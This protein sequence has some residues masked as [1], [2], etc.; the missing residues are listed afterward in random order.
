M[1]PFR[2][3]LAAQADGWW[4][5]SVIPWYKPNPMP[6]SVRKRPTTGGHEYIL[7]LS[8]SG[9]A[10]YWTHERKRGSRTKPKADYVWKHK[11]MD[12]VVDYPPVSKR[13]LKKFWSRSN[14]WKG[15]DYFYDIDAVRKPQTD[16]FAK[17]PR[18]RP[19][20][21]YD[22]AGL[23]N[24]SGDTRMLPG[25]RNRRTS[26]WF[27]EGMV[28]Q[29][30]E[31]CKEEG[32]ILA[33]DGSPIAFVVSTQPYP[34]AHFATFPPKLVEPMVLLGAPPKVCAECGA[35]W[36]RV[37]EKERNRPGQAKKMAELD[38]EGSPMYRGGHHNDGLPYE[39]IVQ[40]LGWRPTCQHDATK[41]VPAR[42]LDLFAGRGTVAEKCIELGRDY[43]MIEIMSKYLPMI[44]ES[45]D[46]VQL[47]LGI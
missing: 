2:V 28:A 44:E 41:T 46:K 29:F 11:N 37:V 13:I 45:V 27:F 38:Y 47:A 36:E 33:D 6:E 7:L 34:K 4:V 9:K 39:G 3:A 20:P 24:R 31:N 18:K 43:V 10:Q 25:G 23:G 1:I 8:K 5:H 17:Y 30:M 14:L 26:D 40:T 22:E 19:N 15:H 12:C 42:V 16:P 35:P 21:K 32:L